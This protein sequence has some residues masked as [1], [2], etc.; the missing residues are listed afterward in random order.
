MADP[1][2]GREVEVAERG[3]DPVRGGPGVDG[4][5]AVVGR[6]EPEVAEVVA[7]GDLDAG[8]RPQDPWRGEAEPVLGVGPEAAERQPRPGRGVAEPGPAGG[9]GRLL[10]VAEHGVRAGEAGERAAQQD[11]REQ[12]AH[13]EHELEVGDRLLG[14]SAV[15]R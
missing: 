8:F 4:D 9:V 7:L 6:D 15:G 12:V 14:P 13:G 11:G 5:D 2:V 3:L 1:A 10:I